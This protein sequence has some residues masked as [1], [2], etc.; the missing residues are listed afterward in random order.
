MK[1]HVDKLKMYSRRLKATK[2]MT[3]Q[4]AFTKTEVQH[5]TKMHVDKLKRSPISLQAR[6]KPAKQTAS[7]NTSAEGVKCINRK[8]FVFSKA[9]KGRMSKQRPDGR[10]RKLTA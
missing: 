2:Q 9:R 7:T 10:R 8:Y 4:A 6:I 3:K 1:I 5:Y